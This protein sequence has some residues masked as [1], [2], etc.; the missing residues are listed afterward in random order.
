MSVSPSSR[1][2]ARCERELLA[3]LDDQQ[4]GEPEVRLLA[5]E[6]VRVRVI[7]VGACAVR[8]RELVVV[9]LARADRVMRMAVVVRVDL[10][11]VPVHDARLV[12]RVPVADAQVRAG[13]HAQQRIDQRLPP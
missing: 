13:L 8:D 12:E 11:P 5:R 6:M 7:P 4:P 1:S 9:G 2:S 3:V 10:E